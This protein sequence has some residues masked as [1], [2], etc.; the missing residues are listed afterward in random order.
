MQNIRPSTIVFTVFSYLFFSHSFAEN[1]TDSCTNP[2]IQILGSGGPELTKDRASSSY[3]FWL[4]NEAIVLIDAGAG[5]AFRYA[6]SG[7]KWPHLKAILFTHFHV[8]HSNDLPALIKA[9]WFDDRKQ[10]LPVFGPYAN[11]IMPSTKVFFDALFNDEN[12]AY[13]YLSD[14]IDQ[15]QKSAYKII[16]NDIRN[17][18]KTQLIYSNANLS[19]FAHQVDHGPIPAFAYILKACGKTFVFSGDTNGSGFEN[20][21]LNNTDVFIAHNAIPENAREIAR[22]LHMIPSQIGKIA[23]HINTKK[24]ILSHRMNRTLGKE[25]ETLTFIKKN[26][27]GT[28]VFSNDL[29]VFTADTQ[30]K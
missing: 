20:L 5:S 8:D 7:A 28:I 2:S 9:S 17:L 25:Q 10:N 13:Q 29:D 24:L 12:G 19:I 15:N 21:K 18:K 27:S 1:H 30:K 23:K 22:S 16:P 3:L 14:M 11:H 26:Y 6:Q 4:N